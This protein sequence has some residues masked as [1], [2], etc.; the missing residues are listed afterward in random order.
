R[1]RVLARFT[2]RQAAIGTAEHYRAA[3]AAQSGAGEAPGTPA[4]RPAAPIAG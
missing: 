2:W 3:I 4:V 1:D